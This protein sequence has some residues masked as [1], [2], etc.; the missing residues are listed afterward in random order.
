M[1]ESN[2]EIMLDRFHV[3]LQE[4]PTANTAKHGNKGGEPW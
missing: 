3:G 2:K 1:C 4:I